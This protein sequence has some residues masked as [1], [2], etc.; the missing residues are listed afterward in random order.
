[1]TKNE[2]EFIAREEAEKLHRLHL[3][4]VR[5]QT[6][7]DV[8]AQKKLHHMKCGNCGYDLATVRWR[9]VDV[10]KCFR[11]GSILLGEIELVKLA[12]KEEDGTFMSSFLGLFQKD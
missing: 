8:A 2:D 7:K 10:E 6:A 11:C 12:G 4:K 9:N 3:D 1:M 5:A